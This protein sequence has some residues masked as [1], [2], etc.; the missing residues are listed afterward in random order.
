MFEDIF[1]EVVDPAIVVDT[2][3][4][5]IETA[6]VPF[7]EM[8]AEPG[9]VVKGKGIGNFRFTRA[10]GNLPVTLEDL[11]ENSYYEDVIFEHG[12]D[13]RLQIDLKVRIIT[14]GD[15]GKRYSVLM[16]RDISER[17][18]LESDLI[19][20]HKALVE[21]HAGLQ[22]AHAEA[23][24]FREQL[25]QSGK[26]AALGVLAAGIAHELN[27]PLTGIRGFSQ[28]MLFDIKRGMLEEKSISSYA[29]EIVKNVDRMKA[30][31]QHLREFVRKSTEPFVP[32]D[33]VEVINGAFIL[34]REQFR[35]HGIAIE[36]EFDKNLPKILSNPNELE[37]AFLNFLTNARDAVDARGNEVTDKKVKISIKNPD[38]EIVQVVFEDN[39][40]GMSVDT[41]NRMFEPFFTTK[42]VGKGMGLG[43]S[44]THSIL[45][46]LGATIVVESEPLKGTVI[47]IN[48]PVAR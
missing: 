31:I 1:M 28:E 42:E 40:I 11:S 12:K 33:V 15:K 4:G 45:E 37:Q 29:T 30:I 46:R 10:F 41:K 20:K 38:R 32:T 23:E 21:A 2:G 24:S 34:L 5:K 14:A 26:L 44:I 43:M 17:K 22:K 13:I 3:K 16:L 39:G 6:N 19:T 9:G 27:Q 7:L 18:K 25:V 35:A 8:I 48:L 36:E 47:K